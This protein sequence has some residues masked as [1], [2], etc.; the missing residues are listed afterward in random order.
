MMRRREF[1]TLLGGAA[2]AW[3]QVAWAQQR[4][5][6]RRFGVLMN[7]T[8]NDPE[9]QMRFAAFLQGLQE[10]GWAVG[11]NA[12]IDVRWAAGDPR[13][14]RASAMELIA[15]APDIIMAAGTLSVAALQQGHAIP[16]VFA[17]VSDPVGA[18]FVDSLARPGGNVTGFMNFEYSLS[19]KWPELLKQIAPGVTRA[20]V[21]RDAANP[22]GI[23]QFCAIQ[24]VG[25]SLGVE[26]SAV[27]VRSASEIEHAVAA[28]AHSANGGLIVTPSAATVHRSH[29]SPGGP[30]QAARHL[31][32]PLQRRQRRPDLVRTRLK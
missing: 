30:A 7:R 11:R 16:I 23:G 13:G 9:G 18:G 27:N 4:E 10:A 5:R 1:I 8:A 15:L 29:H 19:G 24:A 21:L 28:F 14:F 20:A 6:I 32:Q 25:S 31:C 26:L 2:A 3:P 22:A 17:V 12:R